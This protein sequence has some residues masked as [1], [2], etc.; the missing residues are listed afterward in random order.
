MFYIILEER[1]SGLKQ[2]LPTVHFKVIA[3]KPFQ[4][5]DEGVIF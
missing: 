1:L 2:Y 4:L 5:S 3:I